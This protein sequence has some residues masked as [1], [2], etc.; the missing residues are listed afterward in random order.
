MESYDVK[1][2]IEA[3]VNNYINSKEFNDIT[4]KFDVWRTIDGWEIVDKIDGTTVNVNIT[5]D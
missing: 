3:V 2:Y 5:M 4:D 1:E